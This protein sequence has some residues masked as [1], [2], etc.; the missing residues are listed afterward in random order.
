MSYVVNLTTEI[1]PEVVEFIDSIK[2][3]VKK[4]DSLYLI[5][6]M[7]ML[8]GKPAK[9]WGPN[10]IGFGKFQYTNEKG[11]NG[12]WFITGFAQR[13]NNLA[14]YVMCS[15]EKDQELLNELG[16]YKLGKSC[17]YTQQLSDLNLKVLKQVIINS[18]DGLQAADC[19]L[20]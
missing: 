20:T 10:L 1:E 8:T 19:V 11:E 15:L 12:D 4:K 5:E 3:E 16:K 18:I 2:L 13:K 6:L 7:Q 17:I 9:V 14:I